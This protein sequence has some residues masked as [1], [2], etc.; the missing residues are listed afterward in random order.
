MAIFNALIITLIGG[1]FAALYING[2]LMLSNLINKE[3]GQSMIPGLDGL[4]NFLLIV[5]FSICGIL[6]SAVLVFIDSLPIASLISLALTILLFRRL[7]K[8]S[9]LWLTR[10][11]GKESIMV[12]NVK[13]TRREFGLDISFLTAIF[14]LFQL[15]S[16]L[17]WFLKT[18][19]FS[20]LIR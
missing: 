10:E 7:I 9:F 16:L 5:V 12:E 3:K 1:V 14:T 13:Y 18:L 15:L 11:H 8:N 19:D 2:F 17:V 4:A 20:F 6:L